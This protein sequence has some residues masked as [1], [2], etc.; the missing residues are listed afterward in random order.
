LVCEC[1]RKNA[2]LPSKIYLEHFPVC[3]S[4]Q[5]MSRPKYQRFYFKH[6]VDIKEVRQIITQM[7][8]DMKNSR[9]KMQVTETTD[10]S[11]EEDDVTVAIDDL[12]TAPS[13]TVVSEETTLDQSLK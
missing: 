5:S 4:L 6:Y 8:N 10:S 11:S 13:V 9:G 2:H 12:T 1:I 7:K 3:E